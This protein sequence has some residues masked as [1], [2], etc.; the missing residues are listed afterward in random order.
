MPAHRTPTPA[1][2]AGRNWLGCTGLARE[3]ENEL[4]EYVRREVGWSTAFGKNLTSEDF[5]YLGVFLW[6]GHRVH[7]WRT[8]VPGETEYSYATVL[9]HNGVPNWDWGT[10]S[11][12]GLVPGESHG[13]E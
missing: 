6:E 3:V 12:E 11:P 4:I 5:E 7:H 1:H 13:H 2:R 9:I 10:P 8:L